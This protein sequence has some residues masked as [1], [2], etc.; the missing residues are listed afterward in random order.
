MKKKLNKQGIFCLISFLF[1]LGCIIFYGCRLIHYYRVFN[2]SKKGNSGLLSVEIP[3]NSTLV[4]EGNGLYRL[5]GSYVYRGNVEDNYIKYSGLLF[6]ILKINYGSN[7]EI[8][9]DTKINDLT[10]GKDANYKESDINKYLNEIFINNINKDGLEKMEICIDVKSDLSD[11]QCEKTTKVYSTILDSNTYLNTINDNTY[12]DNDDSL[13]YLRDKLNNESGNVIASKGQIYYVDG[14]ESYGIRPILSLKYNTKIISGNGTKDNPYI[15]D[16]NKSKLGS[17]VSLGNYN[18]TIIKEDK[19]VVTLSLNG[20]LNTLK[21]FGESFDPKDQNSVAYYLNNEFIESLNFKDS[22]IETDFEIGEYTN[23]YSSIES[24]TSKAKV[25]LLSIKDFKFGTSEN[26]YL[27]INTNSDNK[28]YAVDNNMTV[29]D[30]DI[31]KA[32]KPVLRVKS[33]IISEVK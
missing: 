14:S 5:N 1:V 27:L 21:P 13:I 12:L 31:S 26:Q 6:R 32:I 29:V 16:E 9:L 30:K 24:K 28:V 17:T 19:D 10:Y 15:V 8:I 20:T 25:G 7:I 2:P 11:N 18:W 22:I 3:K 4:T 33:S 23:K